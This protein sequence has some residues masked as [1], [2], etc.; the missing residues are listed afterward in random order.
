MA[1]GTLTP[2]AGA[3]LRPPTD[4]D[5]AARH[6]G[7]L[8]GGLAL[9]LGVS[10][11]ALTVPR[12]ATAV[13]GGADVTPAA[14]P[15]TPGLTVAGVRCGPKVRQVP[16]SAYSPLC[17]PA[18]HGHNGGATANG[19]TGSTITL[20][21]REASTN[22]L[23]LLYAE[24]PQTVV[25][26]NAEAIHT[27]QSY[28]DVFNRYFELYGRKVVLKP[29]TGQ[30]DFISEDQGSGL[31]QAQE[32]ALTVADSIHGFADMSLIDS[33]AIYDDA[34][35][36]AKVPVFGLYL[37][38]AAWYRQSQPYQYTVGPNCTQTDKALGDLLGS[39][40]MADATAAYAGPG[41]RSHTRR[42]G[43]IYPNNPQA[44]ACAQQL[45]GDLA[46]AGHPPAASVGFT[47]DVATLQTAAQNAIG[48]LKAAGVTTVICAS[49]DPVSPIYFL[50]A[51]KAAGYY[52]ET[53]VQSYFTGG[54]SS[55]DGVIQ[56]ILAKSGAA[57]EGPGILALGNGGQSTA[58][59]EALRA[60]A[61]ANHGSEA[62]ILPTYLWAY[63]SLLYFFDLLQAAGPDLTPATLSRARAD[64]AELPASLPGGSLGQWSF[65]PGQ[66][67][68]SASFQLVRWVPNAVSPQD[69]RLGTFEP[70]Y[71]GK[72]FS[73]AAPHG[74]VPP[75]QSPGCPA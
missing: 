56:N 5:R 3:P 7:R 33:S 27:M 36:Q 9:L 70:C 24:V 40:G 44:T 62:G 32:D 14:A 25:G 47:F 38:D 8:A 59:S 43:I 28:I 29:Y 35:Q 23:S 67:D 48:Q 34:L 20:T 72:V 73:Y 64:T 58:G 26:T 22:I 2:G 21:Y 61:M 15:G 37:Q 11:V 51:A 1:T 50:A 57:G 16:F 49:C 19:V 6:R 68:P 60:Y 63:A 53:V 75:H 55:I 42:Y 18:W 12:A 30:G 69:G 65:G 10:V 31:A 39:P 4:V 66:V 17:V 45:T 74:G 54:T 46:A 13:A 41:L 52:P 71:G